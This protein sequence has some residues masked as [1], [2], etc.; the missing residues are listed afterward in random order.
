MG[1][2]PGWLSLFSDLCRQ[3]EMRPGDAILDLG[4]SELFCSD[5][6]ESLNAVLMACGAPRYDTAELAAMA[7]R[8]YARSLF[9]RAGFRYAAIDYADY[10]GVLRLDL[11]TAAL[12]SEHYGRYQFV[13]NCGTSEHILNQWNVFKTMHEAAAP[14]ALIYHGVPGWGDFEHGIFEYSPKFFWALAEQNDYEVLR[15]WAW[16]E[17]RPVTLDIA[18]M[19]RISFSDAPVAQ[20]VWLHILLRKR[21]ERPFAG[22]DDPSQSRDRQTPQGKMTFRPRIVDPIVRTIRRIGRRAIG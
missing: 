8:S 12:P 18:Q 21:A 3:R 7:N 13:N 16:V 22:L 17:G 11:N 20:K 10:P 4:A 14:G 2:S 5:E 6:P 9:E 15:F 19:P 1:I